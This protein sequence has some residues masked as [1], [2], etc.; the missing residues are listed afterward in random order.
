M[1]TVETFTRLWNES[2]AGHPVRRMSVANKTRK[3][4]IRAFVADCDDDW[5]DDEGITSVAGECGDGVDNDGDGRIDDPTGVGGGHRHDYEDWA[6]YIFDAESPDPFCADGIDNDGDGLT[7]YWQD[8]GCHE[9]W[10]ITEGPEPQCIDGIDNDN[11]GYVDDEDAGCYWTGAT[12]STNYEERRNAERRIEEKERVEEENLR[13]LS[14]DELTDRLLR[15]EQTVPE[16]LTKREAEPP[17]AADLATAKTAWEDAESSQDRARSKWTSAQEAVRIARS[18]R[19]ERK[20][21]P[22][23]VGD[24]A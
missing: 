7:D 11:D 19:D 22:H 4:A 21:T 24:P 17:I 2:V 1:I 15:L 6:C 18:I 12:F 9:P 16:Y 10:D 20:G 5:E 3:R 8:F 23:V 14:Y 13:D